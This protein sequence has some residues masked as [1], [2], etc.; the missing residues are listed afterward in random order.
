MELKCEIK[1]PLDSWRKPVGGVYK[2][3]FDNGKIYVGSSVHLR[4]RIGQWRSFL[5][6]KA[7]S[8]ISPSIVTIMSI[9][10][11]ATV[12]VMA[13]AE[14]E[15]E[16]RRL[17]DIFLS[18]HLKDGSLIN[19]SPAALDNFGYKRADGDSSPIPTPIVQVDLDGNVITSFR[20]IMNA[21]NKTGLKYSRV[22]E[23][24]KGDRFAYR[25][26]KFLYVDSDGQPIPAA[27]RRKTGRPKK[28][29]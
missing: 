5:S 27:P 7:K 24:L 10:R 3:T 20:S 9:C 16:I 29:N 12:E 18:E 17:E 14:D 23:I 26:I 25:G 1:W 4:R 28:T 13:Y 11:L 6:G 2:I 22:C 21:A 15:D 8:R 19:Q